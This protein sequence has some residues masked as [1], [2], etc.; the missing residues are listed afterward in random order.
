[1]SASE[2]DVVS[3]AIHELRKESEKQA[4]DMADLRGRTSKLSKEIEELK[5]W[6]ATL[7]KSSDSV[8]LHT[9]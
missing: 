4:R 6:A 1:M 5:A 2:M 7:P 3:D 8:F 9:H